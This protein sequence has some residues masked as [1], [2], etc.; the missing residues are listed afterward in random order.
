[1]SRPEICWNYKAYAKGFTIGAS[2]DLRDFDEISFGILSDFEPYDSCLL[3][4]MP[5]LTDCYK[6][7]AEAMALSIDEG[8]N[9]TEL[10]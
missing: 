3:D 1:M 7:L 4:A 5:Y 9:W 8:Y 2:Y 10:K 6:H